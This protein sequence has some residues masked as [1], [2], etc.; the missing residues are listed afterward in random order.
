MPPKG[1][2]KVVAILALGSWP[3]QRFARAQ[4]KRSVTKCEMKTHTPKWTPILGVGIPMDFWTFREWLQRS[5]HLALRNPLYHRKDIEVYMSKMGLHD[6][7]GHLQHKLWQKERPG[8]KI[9]NLT[10]YHNK[11][12]IDPT[13]VC[14]GDVWHA[15]GK[16]LTRV[17]T[18]F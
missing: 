14:A 17:V 15:I 7:F 9:G 16:L 3:R 5:K 6:P 8:V 12:G 11:S 10:P 13:S 18:L 4:A 2:A 1:L